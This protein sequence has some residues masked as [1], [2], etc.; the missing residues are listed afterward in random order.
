[1]KH[2]I[3]GDLNPRVSWSIRRRAPS[4]TSVIQNFNRAADLTS[5]KV[6]NINNV[7]KTY[8]TYSE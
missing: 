7:M 1:M 6:C 3:H 2:Y 4:T 8:V 5:L